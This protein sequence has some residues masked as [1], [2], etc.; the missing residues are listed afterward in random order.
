MENITIR[1]I[2]QEDN[3]A[4]AQLIRDVLIEH[5]VPK[6]GTAY[7]DPQLDCMFETYN[8]PR[9]S[10]FV[11]QKGDRLIGGAGI[12]QLQNESETICELQK[13]YFLP[14]ARG[15]GLGTAMMEKCLSAAKSF[16][17]EKCYLETMPYMEA[18]QKLYK[19]SGFGYICAPMGN[20][21]HVACPVWMIKDL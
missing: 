21:G 20:T 19:K 6:V 10:Y 14:E 2:K 11:I 15:L 13:M 4:V 17:Y 7:A 5:N 1:P 18:A 3:A 9:A 8:V 16:G 12:S